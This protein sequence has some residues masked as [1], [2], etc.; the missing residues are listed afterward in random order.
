LP[1]QVRPFHKLPSANTAGA[2]EV[3]RVV[4]PVLEELA[5]LRLVPID[6]GRIEDARPH[7]PLGVDLPHGRQLVDDRTWSALSRIVGLVDRGA[8]S[9]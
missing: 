7:Q 1:A 4:D 2:A 3:A 8:G 6:G 9:R 5:E